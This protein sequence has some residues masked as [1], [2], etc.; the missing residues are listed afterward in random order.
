MP[1]AVRAAQ[2]LALGSAAI[3]LVCVASS[4]WLLGASAALATAIPFVPSWLLGLIALAFHSV[5]QSVRIGGIL[6]AAV[7]MLW[8]VP[9][10]TDGR[11]PGPLGPLISLAVIMLLF[12]REAHDWFGAEGG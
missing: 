4:G 11:P 6:A 9:S 5:G 7:N 10:I 12:Q 1:K 8:T 3:G 2:T